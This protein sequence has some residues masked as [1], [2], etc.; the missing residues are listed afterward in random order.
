MPT[1]GVFPR[2]IPNSGYISGEQTI[3]HLYSNTDVEEHLQISKYHKIDYSILLKTTTLLYR[4]SAVFLGKKIMMLVLP[5][6]N[7]S[8]LPLFAQHGKT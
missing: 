7:V 5:V 4:N 8:I 2:W 3:L 1:D 6:V